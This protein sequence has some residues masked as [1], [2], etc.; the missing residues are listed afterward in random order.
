MLNQDVG[1][2]TAD[3]LG[4]LEAA[5]DKDAQVAKAD[6]SHDPQIMG[7]NP[8]ELPLPKLHA[9]S[10]ACTCDSFL[11]H[12]SVIYNSLLHNVC[13][14]PLVSHRHAYRFCLLS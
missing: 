5:S 9:L 1:V 2:K 14:S 4:T 7:S 12:C 11:G 13:D 8:G 6:S 10:L 3:F